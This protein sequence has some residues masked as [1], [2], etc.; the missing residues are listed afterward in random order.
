MDPIDLHQIAVDAMRALGLL[1]D[2]LVLASI[3]DVPLHG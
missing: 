3:G 2:H 1:P